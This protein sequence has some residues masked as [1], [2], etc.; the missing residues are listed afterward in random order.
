MADVMVLQEDEE[1]EDARNFVLVEQIPAPE[2][3]A[4][5]PGCGSRCE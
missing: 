3:L 2:R 5:L 1:P 4:P